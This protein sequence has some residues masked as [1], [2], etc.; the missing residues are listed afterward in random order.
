MKIVAFLLSTLLGFLIAH[1]LLHGTAAIYGS[2]L[3]SY[4]LYL[5]FLILVSERGKGL[6]LPIGSSIVTHLAFLALLIGIGMGRH[7]IPLFG[8]I[9]Y[10]TPSLAPF[11]AE[12]LF[13]GGRKKKKAAK[14]EP[15][16]AGTADDYEEF[17]QYLGQKQRRFSRPGRSIREEQ[18]FWQADRAKRQLR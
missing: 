8:L 5:A 10:F 16:F 14:P 12:W 6:S 4:H 9:R 13:S 2:L 17:L 18:V 15:M 3:I 7:Y 11:E 1:Y